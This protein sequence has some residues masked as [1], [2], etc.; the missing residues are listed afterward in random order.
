MDVLE[1]IADKLNKVGDDIEEIKVNVAKQE[2][3]LSHQAESLDEHIKR[4]ELLESRVKPL[5]ESQLKWAFTGKV[6]MSIIGLAGTLA[7]IF[8]A[9]FK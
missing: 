9:F 3:T 7:A 5:E 8:E 4:T 6:V 2:V 1:R